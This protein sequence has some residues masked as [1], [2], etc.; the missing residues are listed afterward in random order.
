M[1]TDFQNNQLK[2]LKNL[3]QDLPY[4][5]IDEDDLAWAAW[6][7]YSLSGSKWYSLPVTQSTT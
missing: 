6:P 5:V 2:E 1:K 3:V 7:I 4:A